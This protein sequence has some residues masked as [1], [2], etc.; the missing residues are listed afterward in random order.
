MGTEGDRQGAGQAGG[1]DLNVR[2]VVLVAV[3]LAGL[4]LAVQAVLWLHLQGLWAAR[5][6]EMPPPSPVARALPEAPPEPRLQTSPQEELKTLR[7]VEEARLHGWGWVDRRSGVVR[8]PI[9][10][11]MELVV[12]EGVR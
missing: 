5:R 11:A 6:A 9:E 1:S 12:S 4:T 8:I 7:A 3:G 10:R 2:A